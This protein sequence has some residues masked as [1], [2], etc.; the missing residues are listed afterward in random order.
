[1]VDSLSGGRIAYVHIEG[2]D[3]PSFRT[4][5]DKL[6]GKYRNREAVVVDTRY[7]GGGWLHN[8]VALL[9]SGKEYVRFTPRGRYIGS[10][11]FSQWTK[12]SAMLVNESNYSDA[13]GTPFVYQTL[14]IGDIVGAP[15]P[16]T[17]TAVWWETQIDPSIIFGIPQVTSQNMKGEVL[18]NK[19]L[20][21]D[22][23]VYNAPADILEG[24]DAQ[25]EAA[26]KSL[27]KKITK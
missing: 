14:G 9:L 13:H 12:P 16:G 6:L 18:E 17:M 11:P 8:D 10:E 25:I 15:V 27:M 5:Y 4:V 7:N 2:M 22:I 20:N 3:N 23:V 26:V 19:Q 1:M 24:H 21:P